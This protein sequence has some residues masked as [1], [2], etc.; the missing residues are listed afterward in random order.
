MPPRKPRDQK[1]ERARTVK[2]KALYKQTKWSRKDKDEILGIAEG[3]MYDR[4]VNMKEAPYLAAAH[5]LLE[6]AGRKEKY[7]KA[8][9]KL[10]HEYKD[11]HDEGRIAGWDKRKYRKP[12]KR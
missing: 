4:F 3:I 12:K 2:R 9:A 8:H 1:S 5:A 10:E 7:N 11:H 6:D